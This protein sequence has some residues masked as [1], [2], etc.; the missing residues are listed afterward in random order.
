MDGNA[1]AQLA[2]VTDEEAANVLREILAQADQRMEYG[3]V[4]Y[5]GA[6]GTVTHS[7]LRPS[8]DFRTQLDYSMVPKN[9]DGT[10]DFSRVLAV[11]HSH[12]EWLPNEDGSSGYTRYYTDTDPDRLLY[13]SD[14]DN[15]EDDWDYYNRIT[16]F[17]AGDG[18]DP[19][20]FAM[21]I[22]GFNGTTLELNKY[23]GNDAHTTTVSSG[24][25][26][27]PN[28]TSPVRSCPVHG[29]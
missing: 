21:Y 27:D 17:I 2:S 14:R 13:P 10:T 19:S 24:D 12:A 4:I 8:P 6:D 16:G 26:V 5:I 23:Y 25:P 15:I 18:G 7:P 28:Y 1:E 22:A 9:A 20:L 29:G 3:S 11:V